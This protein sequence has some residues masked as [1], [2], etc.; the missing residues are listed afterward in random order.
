MPPEIVD[1]ESLSPVVQLKK[2]HKVELAFAV[3]FTKT[4]LIDNRLIRV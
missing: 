3:F 4:R 2:S 1:A